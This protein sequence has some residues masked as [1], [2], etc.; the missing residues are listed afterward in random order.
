[1]IIHEHGAVAADAFKNVHNANTDSLNLQKN[2][3]KIFQQVAEGGAELAAVQSQ[4]SEHAQ[5]MAIELQSSLQNMR[6]QEI[7]AMLSLFHGIHNQLVSITTPINSAQFLIQTSKAQTSWSP[8][9][10]HDKILWTRYLVPNSSTNLNM[11]TSPQRLISLDRSFASFE[12]R[13][14]AFQA[15]QTRQ[16]EL[17][18]RLHN[19]MQIEMQVTRGLLDNVT[20]SAT[21][22]HT[23]I[24]T[25][26]AL[27]GQ[28]TSL[29]GNLGSVAGWIW[30]VT[31]TFL[32]LFALYQVSPRCAGYA[33]GAIGRSPKNI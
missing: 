10:I 5:E 16:A 33:L 30:P 29:I 21:G 12:S 27:I 2:V 17:Q 20:L 23:T 32:V 13:A 3:G 7:S 18:T 28:F 19:D 24:Q 1:M 15:A 31:S 6:N 11:L 26:S 22:L 25:T 8:P 14:E 9:C 4:Q